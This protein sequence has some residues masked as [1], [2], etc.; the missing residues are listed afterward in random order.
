MVTCRAR[1]VAEREAVSDQD[2]REGGKL[3]CKGVLNTSGS[4]VDDGVHIFDRP[5]APGEH[6][7]ATHLAAF[8][9]LDR[10]GRGHDLDVETMQPPV[11]A[12]RAA[13]VHRLGDPGAR[14]Q[15]HHLL[16]TVRERLRHRAGRRRVVV[17]EQHRGTAARRGSR[18]T[19]P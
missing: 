11:H 3:A 6:I 12:E 9:D 7:A 14:G 19:D 2:R 18:S 17:V 4:G 13:V 16:V 8:P 5:L 1:Q 10:L 15:Q